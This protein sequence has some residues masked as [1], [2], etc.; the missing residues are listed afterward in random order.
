M[1]MTRLPRAGR[2]GR[3]SEK[4]CHYMNGGAGKALSR[5]ASRRRWYRPAGTPCLRP[6]HSRECGF[7]SS[8]KRWRDDYR[9][10][11]SRVNRQGVLHWGCARRSARFGSGPGCRPRASRWRSHLVVGASSSRPAVRRARDHVVKIA[12]RLPAFVERRVGPE[13]A[14]L[15][16]RPS[17]QGSRSGC[18]PLRVL[19]CCRPCRRARS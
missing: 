11:S 16:T 6:L 15:S 8:C 17:I 10:R 2:Q 3:A 4:R 12:D 19:Q 13:S 18:Q 9:S 7:T 5:S 1:A 14:P